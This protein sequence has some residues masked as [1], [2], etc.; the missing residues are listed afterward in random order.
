R[1]GHNS[2]LT[3]DDARR[4]IAN[5]DRAAVGDV[6]EERV[7]Q[8]VR[9]RRIQQ[10]LDARY[11]H[12]AGIEG[13]VVLSAGSEDVLALLRLKLIDE[14]GERV[15]RWLSE[16]GIPESFGDR[17][18]RRECIADAHVVDA[19]EA[20]EVGYN[21]HHALNRAD[22][23]HFGIGRM[24]ERTG[25]A[26]YRERIRS[27]LHRRSKDYRELTGV[28]AVRWR[29]DRIRGERRDEARRT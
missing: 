14:R 6:P 29:R 25:R 26:G 22:D 1:R 21:V 15:S 12:I 18:L 3:R 17:Q 19:S 11:Q 8:N 4:D 10:T 9:G 28:G 13:F 5:P 20:R 16:T 7:G 2:G 27:R 24:R 23:R